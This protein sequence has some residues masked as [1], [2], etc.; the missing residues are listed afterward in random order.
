MHLVL[1]E[2]PLLFRCDCPADVFVAGTCGHDDGIETAGFLSDPEHADELPQAFGQGGGVF[3]A[4]PALPVRRQPCRFGGSFIQ[5]EQGCLFGG[6]AVEAVGCLSRTFLCLLGGNEA[7]A[8]DETAAGPGFEE[9]AD[10]FFFL[11]SLFCA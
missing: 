5:P 8:G 7:G 11:Q 4:Q 2:D 3:R 1:E 6:G 9:A 10:G